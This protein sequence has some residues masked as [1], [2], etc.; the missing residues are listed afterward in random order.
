[1]RQMPFRENRQGC[2]RFR[3]LCPQKCPSE[4]A[5]EQKVS[6]SGLTPVIN[7]ELG[8]RPG[9]FSNR[10]EPRLQNVSVFQRR[11]FI[12]LKKGF[13]EECEKHVSCVKAGHRY[14]F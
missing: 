7:L 13:G 3:P 4:S 14:Y 11:F 8:R 10:V 2:D 9:R 12:C 1:M 6:S 5:A